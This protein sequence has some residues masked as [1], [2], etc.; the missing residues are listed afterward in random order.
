MYDSVTKQPI[1]LAI[2]RLYKIND[3]DD[4]R[5]RRPVGS[6][7]TGKQ[8]RFQFLVE[9]PGVYQI[10]VQKDGY[11][12][13]SGYLATVQDDGEYLDIY[14][15]EDIEVQEK[16]ATVTPNIPMDSAKE[17]QEP[18]KIIWKRRLRKGRTLSRFWVL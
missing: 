14:H 12:F 7:V 4:G 11:T 2:V 3:T 1:D 9:D 17:A 15:G 6:Q 10:G 8:G 16:D 5:E 13:P 18:S